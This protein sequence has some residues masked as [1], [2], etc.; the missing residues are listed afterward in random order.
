[1][2]SAKTPAIGENRPRFVFR[3]FSYAK[4]S[5]ERHGVSAAGSKTLGGAGLHTVVI[6]TSLWWRIETLRPCS[7]CMFYVF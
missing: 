7:A 1:V 6:R 3:Q 5:R 4:K 2:T